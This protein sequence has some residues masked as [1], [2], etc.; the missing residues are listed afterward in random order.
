M[1]EVGEYVWHDQYKKGQVAKTSG[2]IIEVMFDETEYNDV[3][4]SDIPELARDDNEEKIIDERGRVLYIHPVTGEHTHDSTAPLQGYTIYWNFEGLD[5]A[6]PP[7][8]YNLG[9]VPSKIIK[10]YD[11]FKWPPIIPEDE[12]PY[13]TVTGTAPHFVMIRDKN[14]G[15]LKMAAQSGLADVKLQHNKTGVTYKIQIKISEY[16]AFYTPRKVTPDSIQ[17]LGEEGEFELF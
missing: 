3:V 1:F 14:T 15:E 12:G 7:A 9:P 6:D 4:I 17:S 10:Q 5:P 8:G 13:Y 2:A 16:P 11:Q